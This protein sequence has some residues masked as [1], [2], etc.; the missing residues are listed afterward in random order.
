L[1][2]RTQK[3]VAQ[4]IQIDTGEL[5]TLVFEPEESHLKKAIS[6]GAAA[7]L[8]Y[9]TGKEGPINP[10]RVYPVEPA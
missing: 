7:V 10:I 3:E 9:F 5:D 4:S 2:I 1:Q 6:N 8:K